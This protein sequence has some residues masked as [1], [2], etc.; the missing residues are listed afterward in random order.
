MPEIPHAEPISPAAAGP[1]VL[2]HLVFSEV[3]SEFVVT[4]PGTPRS[5]D[6][7]RQLTRSAL[8]GSP[9]IGDLLLAVSELSTNAIAHSASGQDGTFTVRIRTRAG[10]AR[11]EITDQGPAVNLPQTHNGWG[12]IIVTGVTDRSGAV[13]RANGDRAAWAEVTWPARPP[14]L[15]RSGPGA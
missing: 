2:M 1:V 8:P 6:V 4:L 13:I 12:L 7:A 11:V 3:M 9:R 15:M 5:V 14:R 10:W